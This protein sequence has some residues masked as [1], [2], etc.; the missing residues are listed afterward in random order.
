MTAVLSLSVVRPLP[1]WFLLALPQD[2]LLLLTVL[3]LLVLILFITLFWGS[4]RETVNLQSSLGIPVP[5]IFNLEPSFFFVLC[6]HLF[7]MFDIISLQRMRQESPFLLTAV[8]S[9]LHTA[10]SVKS[11]QEWRRFF[12]MRFRFVYGSDNR[13]ERE[14]KELVGEK[15]K[16]C[17]WSLSSFVSCFVSLSL[18]KPLPVRCS[19]FLHLGGWGNWMLVSISMLIAFYFYTQVAIRTSVCIWQEMPFGKHCHPPLLCFCFV[20]FQKGQLYGTGKHNGSLALHFRTSLHGLPE[21]QTNPTG[22]LPT[23]TQLLRKQWIAQAT[24]KISWKRKKKRRE[25]REAEISIE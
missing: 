10:L 17:C 7:S 4:S 11:I 8:L 1:W 5:H 3:I 24:G 25:E 19:I 16:K 13:T 20:A 6:L 14:R 2:K 9:S 22:F 21:G 12:N 18:W 23:Q 15:K